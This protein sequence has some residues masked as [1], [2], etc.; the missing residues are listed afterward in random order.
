MSDSMFASLLNT[1]DKRTVGDVAHA[2]GQPEQ[3]V[4]RGMETS[5][6][7][8]MGG[9]ASKSQDSGTLQKV[10][11]T[12]SG[13]GGD[14]SWSQMAG[15][16]AA[17]SSS[18]MTAGK[19]VLSTLFGGKENAVVNGIS[20]ASGLTTP[21]A[22]LTMLSMAAPVVMSF[23]T[24]RLRDGGMNISSLGG[25]LQRETAT[26][27][28]ALPPSMHELFWPGATTTARETT[29][30]EDVSPV[31]AQAVQHEKS[32]SGWLAAV[33]L[34]ALGLGLLWFLTHTHKPAVQ[35]TSVPMG[36]ANRTMEEPPT[37]NTACSVPSGLNL[38]ADGVASRLLNYVQSPGD[39]AAGT[40]WFN[41]DQLRFD[42]GI[43]TLK[44]SSQEQLRNVGTVMKDCPNVH[45]TI[46]GYTDN[47]GDETG[48]L[49]LSKNRANAV[50]SQLIAEGV[51]PDRL[52][53]EGYGEQN[54]V[55]DNS[56]AEGRAENRRVAMS[57]TQ[58]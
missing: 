31:V 29:V 39:T 10:L 11:D 12:V 6:A 19:R 1:L 55:A 21:G 51:S 25:L 38:P 26:I 5:I 18:A 8:L 36:T 3:A 16:L 58:R 17:P 49:R 13:A 14:F 37:V 30:R 22:A 40:T 52:S 4:S 28:N 9:M 32:G 45:L 54:P 47:V 44:S 41:A 27:Q 2:L 43:A 33:A 24:R 48:N 34:A 35:V 23:L 42:T 50:R 7:S 46:A 57:V 56:T 53:T 15:S 20:K